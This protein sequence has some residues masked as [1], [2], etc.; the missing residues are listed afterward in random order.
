MLEP[1]NG[2]RPDGAEPLLAD[3]EQPS[4][5][6]YTCTTTPLDFSVVF[7][8]FYDSGH[9]A[10][11]RGDQR[12]RGGGGRQAV[13]AIIEIIGFQGQDASTTERPEQFKKHHHPSNK[14][15]QLTW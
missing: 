8:S 12:S 7:C 15:V 6:T 3:F 13:L 4:R 9:Y 10:R 14:T 5:D 2:Y 1:V 11:Q